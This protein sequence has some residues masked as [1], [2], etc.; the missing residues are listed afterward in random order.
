[1]AALPHV[2]LPGQVLALLCD[3]LLATAAAARPTQ[4]Q[5]PAHLHCPAL[6]PRRSLRNHTLELDYRK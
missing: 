1:M 2:L 3:C 4:P 6:P 5:Q